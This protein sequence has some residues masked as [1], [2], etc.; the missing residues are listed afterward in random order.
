MKKFLIK[1]LV[2]WYVKSNREI[3]RLRLEDEYQAFLFQDSAAIEAAIRNEMHSATLWYFDAV[4][5]QERWIKKGMALG[6]QLLLEKHNKARDISKN[7]D[8]AE[9]IK[10]EWQKFKLSKAGK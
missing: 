9:K 1:L 4:S 10:I 8:K 6:Y 3:S 7:T 5:D 2:R